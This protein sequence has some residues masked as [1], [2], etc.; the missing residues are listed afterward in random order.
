MATYPSPPGPR[1]PYEADGTQ[2]YI[3]PSDRASSVSSDSVSFL[4]NESYSTSDSLRLPV[5]SGYRASFLFPY[6][7]DISGICVISDHSSVTATPSTSVDAVGPWEGTWVP[8]SVANVVATTTAA[9]RTATRTNITN[10]SW[11]GV[12]ALNFTFGAYSTRAVQAIHLYGR[13]SNPSKHLTLWH[14]TDDSPAPMSSLD[15]EDKGRGGVYE[16]S[17][18][19]KNLSTT[20]NAYTVTV[21]SDAPTHGTPD[22]GAMLFFSTDRVTWR[23]VLPIGAIAAGTTSTRLYVRLV[24]PTDAPLDGWVQRI[25]FDAGSWG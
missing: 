19:V 9:V 14:A 12:K 24:L 15:W 8:R 13:P 21:S 25:K 6:A 20:L 23:G 16:T 11:R 5:A 2:V 3:L 17:F 10:V 22:I 1:I 18:R 7:Y 4:N